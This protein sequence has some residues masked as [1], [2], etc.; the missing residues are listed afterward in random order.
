MTI[1]DHN[2]SV[3]SIILLDKNVHAQPEGITFDMSGNLYISNEGKKGRAM[4]Y[5]YSRLNK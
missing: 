3:K 4:L 2:S 5:K 1:L